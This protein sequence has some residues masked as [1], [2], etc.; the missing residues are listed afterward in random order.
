MSRWGWWLCVVGLSGCG[1]PAEEWAEDACSDLLPGDVVITEYLNDPDGT[2]TGREYVELHNPHSVP[3]SLEGLTLHAS[4]SDGSQEKTFLFDEPLSLA[5]GDYLVLGD[6]RE[7]TVPAHVDLSYGDALGALGNASGRLGLRC[8]S[9]VMDEVP[10]TAPSKSGVARVYDGRLVPDSAGN[11]DPTRWC[12]SVGSTVGGSF[13]GS[14][15]AANALCAPTEGASGGDGGVE[16]CSL[17]DGLAARPVRWPRVGE[18]V[19]TELMVNPIGDDTSAEWVE[20]LA[21]APVDLNGLTVGSDT[22]GTRLQGTQCLSLP[23]GGYA[24]LARRAEAVLNGGLP[25]P[26][27]TFGVDLRNSGGVVRVRAGEVVVDAVEYGPAREGVA[28]QLS[29]ERANASDNDSPSSWC[30]AR[31][32][33]GE[34]GNLGTPGRVNTRCAEGDADAG[35]SDGGGQDAGPSDGGRDAGPTSDAGPRDAGPPDAGPPDA[36]PPGSTCIDR[37]TGRARAVRVPEV[38]SIVLTEFMADPTVVAD[39]VG[40][41]VEVLTTREVDLNGITLMNESGA[42][43]TLEAALCLSLKTG[44][45][46]VLARSLD[47][48]LNGGLPAV[49]ATFSFNLANTAGARSLRL[50]KD[51]RALD[52]ITWSNAATPGVSWQVD[53]A[54]SD[55]QRNDLPGSFCAAPSSARYGLGDRGTPGLENRACPR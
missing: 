28:T 3:V 40:E 41:W 23:A 47:P 12:D 5:P 31:E 7:G 26:L 27:A 55:A 1:A 10:L 37:I 24:L 4:R 14:P 11:D 54:S 51:G 45:R 16:K 43:T 42:S 52:A 36:G 35:A 6:V 39:G 21:L 46:A 33:H 9:R 38:G 32:R 18:L 44:T 48:S 34:R 20:V 2:D 29:A 50:M 13:Q 25:T 19:I 8:G 53:P 15:G 30:P 17:L 49:L 22:V